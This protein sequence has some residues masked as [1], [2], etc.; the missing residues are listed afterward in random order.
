MLLVGR[1]GS[2]EGLT[3]LVRDEVPGDIQQREED[4]LNDQCVDRPGD[5]QQRGILLWCAAV[6]ADLSTA[7]RVQPQPEREQRRQCG[8]GQHG[9]NQDLQG[10]LVVEPFAE[11]AHEGFPA[12]TVSSPTLGPGAEGGL[13]S[14]SSPSRPAV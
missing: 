11:A 13:W 3:R 12:L 5:R 8:T 9:E 2:Q 6:N 10:G 4:H 14:W 1:L 7:D